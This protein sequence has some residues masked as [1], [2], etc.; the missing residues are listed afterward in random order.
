M[1]GLEKMFPFP[2]INKFVTYFNFER[3]MFFNNLWKMQMCSFS[4]CAINLNNHSSGLKGLGIFRRC[5]LPFQ[6]YLQWWLQDLCM[7]VHL[8][9]SNMCLLFT[10][11]THTGTVMGK[12]RILWKF[13]EKESKQPLGTGNTSAERYLSWD[14]TKNRS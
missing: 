9:T 6:L 2:S 13:L 7:T 5:Y 10:V 12:C 14:L 3:S 1:K 11:H 4:Q 8:M